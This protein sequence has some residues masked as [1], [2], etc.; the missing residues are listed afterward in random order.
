MLVFITRLNDQIL[1]LANHS[2]QE[3]AQ[4][5]RVVALS[6]HKSCPEEQF[7]ERCFHFL[8]E[9]RRTP[10]DAQQG[11]RNWL[12]YCIC[13]SRVLGHCL[14]PRPDSILYVFLCSC[15]TSA[16]ATHFASSVPWLAPPCNLVRFDGRR[17]QRRRAPEKAPFE[18]LTVAGVFF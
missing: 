13:L 7:F 10:L 2:A 12:F 9:S 1:L 15:V 17:P 3:L 16:S 11:P 5:G 6:S 14:P 8:L 18:L 4:K